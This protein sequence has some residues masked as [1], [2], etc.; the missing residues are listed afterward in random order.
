MSSILCRSMN[1]FEIIPADLQKVPLEWKSSL[2][3]TPIWSSFI[4]QHH[5]FFLYTDTTFPGFIRLYG[6]NPFLIRF[7]ISTAP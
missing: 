6:S 4:A 3:H 5:Q 1:C 2:A 7:I